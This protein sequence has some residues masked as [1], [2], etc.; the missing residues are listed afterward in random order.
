MKILIKGAGDL[1]TGV[2]W[3]LFRAGHRIIMTEIAVPLTVRRQVAYSRAVYEGRAEVEGVTGVLAETA[4]EAIA[5]SEQGR[6]GVLV[7][8]EALIRKVW[9]PEVVIDAIMAK[10][11]IGT[12]IMDAPLVLALGPGFTAGKNCHVVI[13]TMRGEN[14]GRPLYKGSAIPNTGVPGMVGGYAMERLIKASADGRMEPVAAIGDMVEKGSILAYTG[15]QP[16]YAQIGG[17]IR[18]MLQA[19]VPVKAGMKIGDVD[20]R[21][22]ESLV[23]LI[24]DKSHKIGRGCVEAI[25]TLLQ[26]QYGIV[27]LAAGLSK[28][29]GG[30]KLLEERVTEVTESVLKRD[31]RSVECIL[32]QEKE[33]TDSIL[34]QDEKR[35]AGK[36][37][38][39]VTLDKLTQFPD[40]I[41]VVVTRFDEI[42]AAAKKRG[43]VVVENG[44]PELG[45][46][47]SLHLGLLACLERNPY[48]RGVLFMVCDQP[49]LK[50]ETIEQMLEEGL[51]HPQ[52][53]VC[54]AHE[55]RRGNPVF[56]DTCYMSDLLSLTG[57]V[58]GRQ[59]IKKYPE[60][61]RLV[62]CG[63]KELQ[64]VDIRATQ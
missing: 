43:I 25:Q 18:G 45:I 50:A 48:L 10:K 46:S 16:V 34:K 47:H 51:S 60:R 54:A 21:K 52:A 30:N 32:E 12:T 17:V 22:D 11:N 56:W 7:D 49:Y 1:A 64:D 9:Q 62:E 28:R 57:D 38:Y 29:Y 55:G 8:P 23:H 53:I 36:S 24:S 2:A 15:G 20:P 37:L 14:L 63:E 19:G 26:R 33:V 5:L 35:S 44:A 31:E 58:G 59:I 6:I 41:R 3:E 39:E 42:E 61:V 40:C 27:V 13:E 4:E